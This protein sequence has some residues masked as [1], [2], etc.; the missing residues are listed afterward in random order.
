MNQPA[1][2]YYSGFNDAADPINMHLPNP[3]T[4]GLMNMVYASFSIDECVTERFQLIPHR[5]LLNFW[6]NC[7]R[8][9]DLPAASEIDPFAFRDAIGETFILEPNDDCSDFRYRLY[10]T[11]IVAA[12]GV[13]MTGKMISDLPGRAGEFFRPYYRAVCQLRR[14]SYSE[15]DAVPEF[16]NITR[17]CRLALP[18]VDENGAVERILIAMVPKK[19]TSE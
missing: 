18:M 7:R 9:D 5:T 6:L 8:N 2:K 19:K 4:C 14:A 16:S 15:N 12:I 11:M 1:F 3:S 10:G 17:L 13:D